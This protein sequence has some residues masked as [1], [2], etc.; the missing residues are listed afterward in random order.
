MYF[1]QNVAFLGTTLFEKINLIWQLWGK[2]YRQNARVLMYL[3]SGFHP[4]PA[5]NVALYLKI[6][7]FGALFLKKHFFI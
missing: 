3:L 6:L 4:P 5:Q 7:K 2:C 1:T